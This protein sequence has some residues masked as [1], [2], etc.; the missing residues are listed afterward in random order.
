MKARYNRACWLKLCVPA[1]LLGLLTTTVHAQG[2]VQC[3]QVPCDDVRTVAAA[4]TGVPVEHDFS[5]TAGTTYYVTLTDLGA[6]YSAPQPLAT[7][8]MAIT[9]DDQLVTLTP[10]VTTGTAVASTSLVVDGT[11]SVATNGAA[12]ATFTA[13][14]TGSYRFHIIGAPTSGNAPGPIG[15][16]VSATQGGAALQSWSDTIGPVGPPPPSAEGI[17]QQSFFISAAAAGTYQVSLTDLALPQALKA[18]PQLILLQGGTVV[19]ILPTPSGGALT[20]TVTLQAGNYQLFALALAANGSNGGLFSASVVP[21]PAGNGLTAFAWTVPVGATVAVGGTAQL[22]AGAQYSLTLNDLA[23]PVALSQAAAMAVD[24]SQGVSGAKLSAAGT[25]TFT[26]AGGATG[27]TYQVY[28]VAQAAA[29]PGAGSYSA[30]ILN[31]N[32]VASAGGA[33]TVTTAATSLRG[34]TFTANVPAAGSYTATLTDFL[35]PAALSTADFALV[36]GGAVV[37]TP[38]TSAGA[39]TTNLAAGAGALSLLVFASSSSAAGSLMD[40]SV[41]NSTNTLIFDQPQG[42]GVAFKPTQISITTA[43]AYQFTLADLAWPASFSQTGGQL[44]GILTSGGTSLGEIYGGGTLN[45][46]SVNTA[47]NYFLNIIATPTGPDL[48]GTYAL[49]VS[50]APA[51][52]T[53]SLSADATSVASGGTVHLIWTTTGATTCTASGGGWSGTFTGSQATSDSVM[54]PAIAAMTTFTLTCT[55]PGGTTA[56]NVAISVTAAA[57]KGGGGALDAVTLLMMILMLGLLAR[58][59]RARGR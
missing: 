29:T 49:N 45:S 35:L 19:T 58:Q 7:L 1:A 30:Q 25:Q 2:T 20:A 21:M 33:Q 55:G 54:S 15:L 8:K 3:A 38:R 6:Q 26:A 46:I 36:Q 11:N 31:Q 42:V 39:I 10:I 50:A 12:T 32:G 22:N 59:I 17:I 48:A 14:A 9:A 43:G 56:G 18:T 34:Y 4:S 27:D 51:A 28:A 5:A 13:A 37:G 24:I 16:V 41:S 47:G 53:V 52:P 57:A 40:V 23:F 44:T